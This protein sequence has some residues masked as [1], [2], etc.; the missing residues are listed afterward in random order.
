M[1]EHALRE[2][3]AAR[4]VDK[5]RLADGGDSSSEGLDADAN[6]RRSTEVA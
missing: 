5:N 1:F 3:Y 6:R 2:C 4:T